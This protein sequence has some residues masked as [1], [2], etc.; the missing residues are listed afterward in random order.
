MQYRIVPATEDLL[1]AM[2]PRMRAAD[3]A[4]CAAF[5]RGPADALTESLRLSTWAR[6]AL[7]P[8][9]RP[10]AAWGLVLLSALGGVGRPWMLSTAL[11]ERSRRDF[12]RE[13]R[14][15]VVEM[16]QLCPVLRGVT[17]ARYH[18][19]VRWLGWLGF[20]FGAPIEIG[21]APFLPF[22]RCRDA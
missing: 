10:I 18:G 9:G 16:H 17:D 8:S 19:A 11:V 5:G 2:A 15:Q 6:V 3:V 12:L 4:E 7:T 20:S 13:S 14:R 22:E 21:G 1:R